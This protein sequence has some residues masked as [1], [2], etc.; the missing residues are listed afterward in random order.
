MQYGEP[1]YKIYMIEI[2]FVSREFLG[3]FHTL[4]GSSI[5]EHQIHNQQPLKSFSTEVR[6]NKVTSFPILLYL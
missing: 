3:G 2:K 6:P 4:F 5:F 1:Q